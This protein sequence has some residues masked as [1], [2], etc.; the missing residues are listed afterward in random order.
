YEQPFRITDPPPPFRSFDEL[1]GMSRVN[2]MFEE[3][4][5]AL[6]ALERIARWQ[7]EAGEA[8]DAAQRYAQLWP[9]LDAH[10]MSPL[11]GHLIAFAGLKAKVRE[12][13]EPLYWR[14]VGENR[15]AAFYPPVGLHVLSAASET[16]GP[17]TRPTH[18]AWQYPLWLAPPDREIA[19]ASFLL[20]DD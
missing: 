7:L 11:M 5:S 12:K 4:K 9:F 10:G 15:D 8:Y 14:M 19:E 13:Y 1:G 18:G 3:H 16:V 6:Q 17:E 20:Q 2:A